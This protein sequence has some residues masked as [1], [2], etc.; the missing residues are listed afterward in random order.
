MLIVIVVV[1]V[2]VMIVVVV[3]VIVGASR[4]ACEKITLMCLEDT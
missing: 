4:I 3:V 2:P 1:A